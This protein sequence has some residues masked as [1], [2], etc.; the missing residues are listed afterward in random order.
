[1]GADR[2]WGYDVVDFADTPEQAAFRAEVRAFVQERCPQELIEE[3]PYVGGLG[4]RHVGPLSEARRLQLMKEWR[5]ALQERG[6]IAPQWP[7]EYG[8][9]DLSAM[10]RHILSEVLIEIGAPELRVLDVGLTIMEH[11]SEEIKRQLLPPLVR[12]ETRWCQGYS[13]PGAGS[14]LTSL[15][16]RAILDG[17]HF[18]LNGQKIWTSWANESDMMFALVRTS[19]EGPPHRGITFLVFDVRT[20]GISVRPMVQMSGAL[21]F[22]E[23][24][25]DDVRVPVANVVGEI[26]RGWYVAAT[27]LDFERSRLGGGVGLRRTNGLLLAM[28]RSQRDAGSPQRFDNSG[29]RQLLA[30]CTIAAEVSLLL[31]YRIVHEQVQG[32]IP[33]WEASIAKTFRTELAQR[34]ANAAVKALGLYGLLS[35]EDDEET[36]MRGKWSEWYQSTSGETIGAGTSE[37]QRNIIATR[38]LGL[39]RS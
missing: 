38:R 35:D 6:W 2:A 34:T 17:D 14:D 28:L 18:V 37:I 23:V 26:D 30:D 15:Q 25:F 29:V 12:G 39:P 27:H 24:F 3:A 19:T 21:D 11:G 22:N 32:V 13:E 4:G 5:A 1:M 8:G 16:T 33:S 20:P 9:A 7:K 31:T 36:P 10:E